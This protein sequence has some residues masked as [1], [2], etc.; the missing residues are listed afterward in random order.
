MAVQGVLYKSIL[1]AK[2]EEIGLQKNTKLQKNCLAM[3]VL[4]II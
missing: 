3:Y 1:N 4:S 2:L